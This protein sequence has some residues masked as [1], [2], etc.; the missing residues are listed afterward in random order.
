M[1]QFELE[2]DAMN[3]AANSLQQWLLGGASPAREAV[4]SLIG[5]IERQQKQYSEGRKEKGSRQAFLPVLC[6][7][8][9]LK[10]AAI[11]L[12]A[13]PNSLRLLQEE[14]GGE[15]DDLECR[16]APLAEEIGETCRLDSALEEALD[17][18]PPVSDCLAQALK[19]RYRR[20]Q[21]LRRQLERLLDDLKKDAGGPLHRWLRLGVFLVHEAVSSRLLESYRASITDFPR[22]RKERRKK[23]RFIRPTR[24]G[25][26]TLKVMS[27]LREEGQLP[28]RLPMIEPPKHWVGLHGGGYLTNRLLSEKARRERHLLITRHDD[29]IVRETLESTAE[30]L[31]RVVEIINAL[32]AVEWRLNSDVVSVMEKSRKQRGIWRRFP[33]LDRQ[34]R[35]AEDA[36]REEV[37]RWT[38][39]Q[40]KLRF[41]RRRLIPARLRACGRYGDAVLWFPWHIDFRARAYPIPQLFNPQSDDSGRGLLQFAEGNPVNEKAAFWLRVNLANLW[42]DGWDKK[43]LKDRERFALE[44]APQISGLTAANALTPE[45]FRFWARAEKPWMFLAACLDFAGYL[46]EGNKWTSHLPVFLDGT[47]NGLQHLSALGRDRR[48]ALATNLTKSEKPQDIY[49]IVAQGLKDSLVA[50]EK[51]G[52]ELARWW[53]KR[54][55]REINRGLVKH[56]TMAQP[57]GV[58]IDG[59][60][61]ELIKK[62][63]T[64]G[65]NDEYEAAKY[66]AKKLDQCIQSVIGRAWDIKGWLQEI[67][68]RLARSNLGMKWGT[69]VINLPVVQEERT[70]RYTLK[71]SRDRRYVFECFDASK[72]LKP[73]RAKFGIVA[74]FIHSLDATHMLL[75]VEDLVHEKGIK[76]IAT[77]HDSFGVHAANVDAL[78]DSLRR[79]FQL[80]HEKNLLDEFWS[81]PLTNHPETL[82]D[83]GPPPR[84]LDGEHTWKPEEILDSIYCFS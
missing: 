7:F 46:K 4:R 55:G 8:D 53:L 33:G 14:E 2:A 27:W 73:H 24:L 72:S 52:D 57:Y 32:Q 15:G 62:G 10:L 54:S 28:W 40:R 13:I 47:C 81:G 77:V 6:L 69:P 49:T 58:T 9:S 82:N 30:A 3:R 38:S 37:N 16:V 26:A 44:C 36:T 34:A 22:T 48:G 25:Y 68:E 75:T 50:S 19:Q 45:N 76:S 83:I 43:P 17:R 1:R 66:L 20:P 64:R 11:I 42:G 31:K 59:V 79:N 74:N 18:R 60:R 65:S 56:A 21:D 29:K 5:S 67:A 63:E 70:R 12:Q 39:H 51:N 41:Y 80:I 71:Y 61:R 78:C 84:A 23:A 35:P